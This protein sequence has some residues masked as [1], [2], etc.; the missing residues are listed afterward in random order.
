MKNAVLFKTL[1]SG[2]LDFQVLLKLSFPGSRLETEG[3]L[4]N[5]TFENSI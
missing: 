2:L 5:Q 1:K 3:M 4:Q